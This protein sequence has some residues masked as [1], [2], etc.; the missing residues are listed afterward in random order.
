MTENT[1][2]VA[3]LQMAAIAYIRQPPVVEVAPY[4]GG[5]TEFIANQTL[6]RAEERLALAIHHLRPSASSKRCSPDPAWGVKPTRS[7]LVAHTTA[8]GRKAVEETFSP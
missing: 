4:G 5:T 3:N 8:A 1:A 7:G 2:L 6:V